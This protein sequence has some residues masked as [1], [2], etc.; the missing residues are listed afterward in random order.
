LP[1]I[2]GVIH[3]ALFQ[4]TPHGDTTLSQLV[5][6]VD[7]GLIHATRLS[8]CIAVLQTSLLQTCGHLTPQ[9]STGLTMPSDQSCSSVCIRP[10]SPWHRR[11][12]TVSYH[13]VVWTGTARCGW[14][15]WLMATTSVSL[16][17]R[18]KQTFEHNLG[19]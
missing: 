6:V 7:S 19:L 12:A 2:N 16:C 14:R 9:T 15:H 17:R 8:Y 13:R 4:S 5:D 10:Q 11:A 18:R 1:L 3:S